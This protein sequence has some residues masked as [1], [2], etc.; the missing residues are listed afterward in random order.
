MAKV[1]G[2]T[3]GSSG[4]SKPKSAL[5][6]RGRSSRRSTKII[7]RDPHEHG[8]ARRLWLTRKFANK[9]LRAVCSGA[10]NAPAGVLKR[11]GGWSECPQQLSGLVLNGVGINPAAKLLLIALDPLRQP[12]S[13]G[14]DVED[15]I[16]GADCRDFLVAVQAILKTAP[17]PIIDL[18]NRGLRHPL[19]PQKVSVERDRERPAF[20]GGS[21]AAPGPQRQG[22][23]AAP[24]SDNEAARNAHAEVK[25]CS[26]SDE[27]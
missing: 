27:S 9:M 11:T 8:I 6:R 18:L 17:E 19:Q 22:E 4:R 1:V 25:H 5:P 23:F 13:F 7:R 20:M 24:D 15:R 2:A 10:Q 3:P 14:V 21:V 16:A 12:L 26:A